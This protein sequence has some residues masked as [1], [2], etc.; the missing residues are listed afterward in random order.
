[1]STFEQEATEYRAER[2]AYWDHVN[3]HA[4]Q[5]WSGYYRER[6]VL[7]YSHLVKPGA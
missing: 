2:L 5:A 1:M 4:P 3:A 6:I 7:A